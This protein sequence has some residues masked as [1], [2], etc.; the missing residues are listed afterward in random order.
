MVLSFNSAGH[1]VISE[2]PQA[3]LS[4]AKRFCKPISN[5]CLEGRLLLSLEEKKVAVEAVP[6]IDKSK[7]LTAWRSAFP[8]DGAWRNLLPAQPIAGLAVNFRDGPH[9]YILLSYRTSEISEPGGEFDER[10][11]GVAVPWQPGKVFKSADF[12]DVVVT[13]EG[14]VNAYTPWYVP[15]QIGAPIHWKQYRDGGWKGSDFL[16]ERHREE[17]YDWDKLFDAVDPNKPLPEDC[18]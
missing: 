18:L 12:M 15:A 3:A 14:G 10:Q 1:L 6:G 16:D 17:D 2:I 13:G 7:L 5:E 8:P 4:R 9:E 11:D